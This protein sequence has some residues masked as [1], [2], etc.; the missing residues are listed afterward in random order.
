[1]RASDLTKD[2]QANVRA[3][4]KHLRLRLG[5]WAAVAKAL[6]ISISNMGHIM[7][8]KPVGAGVAIGAARLAGASVDDV[9]AG[10]YP[11]PG[12]CPYC[13]HRRSDF[14]DEDTTP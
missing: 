2:E 1:M 12:T 7:R 3:V 14:I 10:R 5:G 8:T 4:L 13:G 11:P 9:L 6:H